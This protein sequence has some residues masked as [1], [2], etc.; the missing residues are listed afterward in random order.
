VSSDF[1]RRLRAAHSSRKS[2][3]LPPQ[4]FVRDAGESMRVAAD[5]TPP[6]PEP[7]TTD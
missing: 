6:N 5:L 1:E 2:Q 7:K 3:T 4:L